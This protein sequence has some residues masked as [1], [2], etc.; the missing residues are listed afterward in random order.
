MKTII[1]VIVSLFFAQSSFAQDAKVEKWKS[2]VSQ[3]KKD[4]TTLVAMDSLS[5]CM[6]VSEQ[7][8]ACIF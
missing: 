6:V 4:T 3:G 1:V 8:V 2:I 7:T 5:N